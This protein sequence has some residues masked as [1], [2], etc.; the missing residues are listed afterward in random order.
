MT[1][2]TRFIFLFF[3]LFLVLFFAAYSYAYS[4][5]NGRFISTNQQ[6]SFNLPQANLA[7]QETMSDVYLVK[8]MSD[9]NDPN[10]VQYAVVTV[11]LDD[12]HFP[13]Y[14]T[15]SKDDLFHS[16]P[17]R[18][19][20][21]A[22][23]DGDTLK[24]LKCKYIKVG[25]DQAYQCTAKFEKTSGFSQLSIGSLLIKNGELIYIYQYVPADRSFDLNRYN[26]LLHSIKIN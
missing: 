23:A 19:K 16:L 13:D 21:M 4:I 7:I 14:Q 18:F 3:S 9:I 10:P 6:L 1:K 15:R 5:Q 12:R 26:R 22:K 20:Q 2:Y 8:L 11:P 17:F 25:K 24:N